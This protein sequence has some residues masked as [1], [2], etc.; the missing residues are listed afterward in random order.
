MTFIEHEVIMRA[1]ILLSL[2]KKQI[3]KKKVCK[4]VSCTPF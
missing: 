3:K 1:S 2:T 4:T